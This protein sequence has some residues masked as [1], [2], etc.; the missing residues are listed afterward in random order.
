MEIESTW[1]QRSQESILVFEVKN[2]IFHHIK[3]RLDEANVDDAIVNDDKVDDANVDVNV[4]NDN[5]D[6]DNGFHTFDIF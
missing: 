6:D 4:N 1:L 3:N 2:R 5:I